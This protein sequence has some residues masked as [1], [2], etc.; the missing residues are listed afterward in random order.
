VQDLDLDAAL[1]R[2]ESSFAALR[3]RLRD[4]LDISGADLTV[5]QFVARA[6]SAGRHVRVKD[7]AERLGLTGPA[8]TGAIDRLERTGHLQRVP[9]PDDGRSRH[10]EL[11]PSA[12]EAYAAAMD[13]TNEHLH[14]LLASFTDRERAR[15]VRI[16]DRVID[17]L[18]G[19]A[20]AP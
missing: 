20:P 14:E 17:A 11:T 15:L 3:G 18:D 1:T 19:G 16:V 9:N 13:S 2:L 10:I 4:R 7:L 12:R 8:V 6:E 5:V